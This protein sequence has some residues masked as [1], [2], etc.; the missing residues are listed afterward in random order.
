MDGFEVEHDVLRDAGK[1]VG[2]LPTDLGRVGRTIDSGVRDGTA[3]VRGFL[4]SQA[5][6]GYARQAGTALD[7]VGRA[8]EDHGG[9]LVNAAGNY[10]NTDREMGW[11]FKR[12]K[13]T[14]PS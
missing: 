7:S 9:G 10:D 5:L 13:A 8:L 12:L 3:R 6:D 2:R 4:V 1:T 11:M 14:F